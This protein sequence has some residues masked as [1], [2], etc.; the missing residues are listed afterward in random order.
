MRPVL[1]APSRH[2]I[3]HVAILLKESVCYLHSVLRAHSAPPFSTFLLCAC[4]PRA[5]A[6]K[7]MCQSPRAHATLLSSTM[8]TTTQREES[9]GTTIMTNLQDRFRYTRKGRFCCALARHFKSGRQRESVKRKCART[10][11]VGKNCRVP[12]SAWN[13][14]SGLLEEIPRCIVKLGVAGNGL[15]MLDTAGVCL[16]G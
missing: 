7:H 16:V 11:R 15:L 10:W 6:P 9:R 3:F 5:Q 12:P 14:Y 4:V 2:D 13:L 8:S 1:R